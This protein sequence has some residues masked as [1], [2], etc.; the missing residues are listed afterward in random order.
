MMC[1]SHGHAQERP[2]LTR[3]L[4]LSWEND[5]PTRRLVTVLTSP[6]RASSSCS[7]DLE[8]AIL[9]CLCLPVRSGACRPELDVSSCCRAAAECR[10]STTAGAAVNIARI[11]YVTL[12]PC[13]LLRVPQ[14]AHT[15]RR[16]RPHQPARCPYAARLTRA[17]AAHPKCCTAGGLPVACARTTR[18]PRTRLSSAASNNAAAAVVAPPLP[19]AALNRRCSPPAA[20]RR[21]PTPPLRVAPPTAAAPPTNDAAYPSRLVCVPAAAAGKGDGSH[22][23]R[24][25]LLLPPPP[26]P[27]LARHRTGCRAQRSMMRRPW[28]AA[29]HRNNCQVSSR[30]TSSPLL[31]AAAGAEEPRRR[32]PPPAAAHSAAAQPASDSSMQRE[33]AAEEPPPLLSTCR[34]SPPGR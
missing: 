4:P 23:R 32:R 2:R 13:G 6:A 27:A 28:R 22:R 30:M 1:L 7:F 8:H 17:A 20:Y 12:R 9:A 34:A 19:P 21:P 29:V 26:L 11:V 24:R 10:G 5:S 25:R 18:R 33:G 15:H 16:T 31:V 14:G 3:T